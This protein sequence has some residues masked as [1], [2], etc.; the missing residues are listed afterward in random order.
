MHPIYQLRDQG[1][2][3][4]LDY[5]SRELLC[6]GELRRLVEEDG[7]TG[8][9]SNPSIFQKSITQG[10]EYDGAVRDILEREPAAP[11]QT[12]YERLAVDDIR[13][14]ADVLR[15]VYDRTDGADGYVSLE[16]RADLAYDTAG[17][18]AEVR[19]LFRT[20]DRPNVMIKVPGTPPG[21]PAVEELIAEGIN[22]NITLM[23]STGHYEAVS[24]A[25]LRGLARNASP[26][27]VASVA[28]VFVSRV[29]TAVDKQLDAI[30]TPEARALRG[31]VAIANAKAIYQR[32]QEAFSPGAFGALKDRGA[33]VQRVL[34][35]STGTK[36]PAYSDVLYVDELIGPDTINTLPPETLNAF[37]DHGKVRGATVT[38]GLQEA[39]DVLARLPGCGIDLTFVTE[40]L[41]N[42]GVAAFAKSMDDLM[43]DL[44]QKRSAAVA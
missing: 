10:E 34:W 40:Q 36:D 24:Q 27:D 9:T 7:L 35:G 26:R 38:E 14:A 21:I 37:K 23:F 29:D 2:A 13:M 15:S 44:G 17:T 4:W 11:T 32:F 33:R 6:S 8:V 12:V 41:Q 20:V 25:Y 19:R 18:L 31:R 30:G 5:I 43:E 22:I 28:S 3:V 1:Q 16:P 42:D 39:G